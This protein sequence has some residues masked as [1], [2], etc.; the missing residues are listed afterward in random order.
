MCSRMAGKIDLIYRD[1]HIIVVNKPSGM[2]VHK[3]W[4]VGGPILVNVVRRLTGQKKV[5]P[6][7][8]LDRATSGIILLALDEESARLLNQSFRDRAVGKKYL[9]LVRGVTPESGRIDHPIVRAEDGKSQEAT[10]DFKRLETVPAEPRDLSLVL[11]KPLT[12][13]PHQIRR[14][15]KH[16]NHPVIGDSNYGRGR[17]NRAIREKYRLARLALHAFSLEFDHPG[18]SQRICLTAPLP[19]DLRIPL[20]NIGFSNPDRFIT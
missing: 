2:L 17:L 11:V 12:G 10:T 9:A 1:D 8:R 5:F 14:H 6:I 13:R 20:E 4:G 16:I 7:H 19:D 3:G 18:N 15:L